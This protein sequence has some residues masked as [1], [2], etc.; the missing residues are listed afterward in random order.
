[1]EKT[2]KH[3]DLVVVNGY[4]RQTCVAVQL[5]GAVV[6]VEV[7]IFVEEFDKGPS[8]SL[9]VEDFLKVAHKNNFD[10]VLFDGQIVNEDVF[11]R[12]EGYANEYGRLTGKSQNVFPLYKNISTAHDLYGDKYAKGELVL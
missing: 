1:M 12:L 5:S 4:K 3:G 10:F 9:H 6:L 7:S 2:L 11:K 8:T